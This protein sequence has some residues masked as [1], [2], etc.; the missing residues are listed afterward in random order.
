MAGEAKYEKK[1]IIV[2]D[3]I[4]GLE[5]NSFTNRWRWFWEKAEIS[6]EYENLAMKMMNLHNEFYGQFKNRKI[7]EYVTANTYV[8]CDKGEKERLWGKAISHGVIGS[9][10]QAVLTCKDCD[11]EKELG[12]WFGTC[13]ID[14]STY[15]IPGMENRKIWT[16]SA[17][18]CFPILEQEWR[19]EEGELAIAIDET[20]ENF[21]DALRSGAYLTCMYG[22]IIRVKDILDKIEE[23]EKEDEYELIDG[24]LRLYKEQTIP[25]EGR[26]VPKHDDANT[27]DWAM[28]EDVSGN[29]TE[30]WFQEESW[31]C[32]DI[33]GKG[34]GVV[35]SKTSNNLYVD[36]EGRYWVAVGPNV[37]NPNYVHESDEKSVDVNKVFYGTKMDVLV[38]NQ[39]TGERY[40]VRTVNGDT[41][42]HSAPDG[43]Y[44][45]GIPFQ[46]SRPKD[47]EGAGNTV[48][49][50]G[51]HITEKTFEDGKVKS[52]INITNNYRLIGIYVYDGE[53]N[54]E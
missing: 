8:Y 28:P 1:K 32:K 25:G 54:Y 46:S 4:F 35:V 7:E 3:F 24:W 34:G 36:G 14:H 29:Y 33:K 27:W 51:Y 45:T 42:E 6:E 19:Q 38:E 17:H 43:L 9:N 20:G 48:E 11:L 12:G 50:I 37:V 47:T 23:E 40:Y 18:S 39:Y 5:G 21:A 15:E 44:Q 49:F 26:F 41:K 53:F 16:K 31:A 13:E 30:D 22:G 52:S 2:G 10:G